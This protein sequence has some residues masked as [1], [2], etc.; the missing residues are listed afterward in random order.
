M[1]AEKKVFRQ[2]H[3]VETRSACVKLPLE[4]DWATFS[5]CR[6]TRYRD[7]AIQDWE[8]GGAGTEAG[9]GGERGRKMGKREVTF[10]FLRCVFAFFYCFFIVVVFFFFVLFF[11]GPFFCEFFPI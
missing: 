6:Q 3:D 2:E 7:Q 11:S 8:G 1:S 9:R 10:F 5:S 4:K